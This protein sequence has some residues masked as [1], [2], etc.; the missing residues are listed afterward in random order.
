MEVARAEA[1]ASVCARLR[2]VLRA[3]RLLG[4]RGSG[5]LV[6]VEPAPGD[7]ELVAKLEQRMRLPALY[8]EY[9]RHHHSDAFEEDLVL[10]WHGV[11]LLL[12][13]VEGIDDAQGSYANDGW[14][15]D[16]V[17]IGFEYEGCYFIDTTTGAV[18]YLDHGVG[19]RYQEA[20]RDFVEFLEQVIEASSP[21]VESEV[22]AAIAEHDRARLEGL[23]QASGEPQEGELT[24][25]GAAVL[26][27]AVELVEGLLARGVDVEAVSPAVGCTALGI[28]I[29]TGQRGMMMRLLEHGASP[30]VM[31][32]RGRT[33]LM[34]G[35]RRRDEEVIA[36]ALRAGAKPLPEGWV[37]EIEAAD[38]RAVGARTHAVSQA[39]SS[40]EVGSAPA[41][42]GGELPVEIYAVAIGTV[43]AV[44]IVVV[45]LLLDWLGWIS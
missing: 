2:G 41:K 3:R 30:E 20:G 45:V 10:G 38:A 34:W 12:V 21:A 36:A 25:L 44:L 23:L 32:D 37:E 19:L 18:G 13:G 17:V 43:I 33:V 27:G 5:R 6:E 31:D 24:V 42:P 7:P 35:A 4:E 29:G 26:R 9:L 28:A 8:V 14:P 22:Y 11:S 15:A 40:G 16:W 39:A 1:L